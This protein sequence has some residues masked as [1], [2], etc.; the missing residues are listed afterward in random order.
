MKSENAFSLKVLIFCVIIIGAL[1]TALYLASLDSYQGVSQYIAPLPFVI[2]L[3]GLAALLL[4]LVIHL[5]GRSAIK[6]AAPISPARTKEKPIRREP[7]QEGLQSPS[8]AIQMLTI[9]QRQGRF[10]DF[11]QED[12]AAYSDEQVGAAVR[13]VHQ[14][15]KEALAQHLELKPIMSQE[16]GAQVTVQP[17]FDLQSIRLSGNVSGNPPFKGILRHHGWRVVRVDLPKPV[18]EQ[19]KDWVVAPAEVEV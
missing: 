11:L 16:E 14:G 4:W 15:C 1:V 13:N 2:G 3:G 9:L 18:R 17:G 19:E 5:S 10:I 6:R 12:L 7:G 8:P